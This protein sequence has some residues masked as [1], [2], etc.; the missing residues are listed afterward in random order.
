VLLDLLAPMRDSLS[1]GGHAILSGI[2]TDEREMMSNAIVQSRWEILADDVEEGWWS[3][4]IQPR[5]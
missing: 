1:G 3:V 2:L 4:L 5:P